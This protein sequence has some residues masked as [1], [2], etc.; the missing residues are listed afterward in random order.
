MIE[1]LTL[2][3]ERC[4]WVW[5]PRKAEVKMCPHCKSLYWQKRKESKTEKESAG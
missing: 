3:C 2:H 5:V 1:I 4:G